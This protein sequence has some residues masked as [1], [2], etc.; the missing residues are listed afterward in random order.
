MRGR[1]LAGGG[2][3]RVWAR[4]RAE[5]GRR[6]RHPFGQSKNQEE[7]EMGNEKEEKRNQGGRM[8]KEE[9]EQERE[10]G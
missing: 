10:K 5:S 3:V 6:W 4:A 2:R 8:G 1:G 7:E 9:R